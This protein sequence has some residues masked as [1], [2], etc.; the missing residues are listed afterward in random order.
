GLYRPAPG[1]TVLRRAPLA[2]SG[3]ADVRRCMP[4]RF[5]VLGDHGGVDAATYVELRGQAHEP[6]G[7]GAG[8]VVEDLVGDRLVEAA[9]VAERPQVELQGFQLHAQ[10]VRHV[11]ELQGGE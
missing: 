4:A 1:C 3:Q 10:P 6:R 11:F 9:A 5:A 2:D 7:G 8:E